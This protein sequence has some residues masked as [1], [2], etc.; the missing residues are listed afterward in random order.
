MLD[1]INPPFYRWFAGGV[2][3]TCY[4]ALD[5][6]IDNG[7]GDQLALVYDS[8]VTN[9]IKKYTYNQLRDEVNILNTDGTLNENAGK[10]QGLWCIHFLKMSASSEKESFG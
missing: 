10:Y 8:P 4:N 7:I 1:D 5:Y 9:T 6:H 3:N 2:V